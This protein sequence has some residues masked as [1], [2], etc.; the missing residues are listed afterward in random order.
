MLTYIHE[1][2]RFIQEAWLP[3]SAHIY[4]HQWQFP[5]AGPDVVSK[6]CHRNDPL[7][8]LGV[9]ILQFYHDIVRKKMDG[10]CSHTERDSPFQYIFM[11]AGGTFSRLHRDRGGMS[12]VLCPVVGRKEVT[13][14]HRDDT[15][16]LYQCSVEMN[17]PDFS[18]YPLA[19][20][21]RTWRVVLEPGDILVMPPGTYH[22]ARNL[23]AC[24]S[25]SRFHVDEIDL[26]H[27]FYSWQTGDAP[28][29]S[30]RC[31]HRHAH[32][33]C[34]FVMMKYSISH[35]FVH[36]EYTRSCISIKNSC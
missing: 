13:M 27:H 4:L 15:R 23:D 6:L 25:Y 32:Y 1:Y 14:V 30:H 10:R 22:A 7:P 29:I 33:L 11:G 3:G 36:F 12:I 28:T 16:L 8:I 5:L 19:A 24:L 31:T 35:I 20:F 21:A 18:T 17:A 34:A 26:A 9:D 2:D